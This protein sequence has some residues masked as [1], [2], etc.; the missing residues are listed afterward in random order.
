MINPK[1]RHIP[2]LKEKSKCPYCGKEVTIHGLKY[3]HKRY[4]KA[5]Q[6]EQQPAPMPKLERT[7]TLENV[8]P[9]AP[10]DEQI[11]AFIL[12]QR[13]MKANEKREK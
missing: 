6:S 1:T 2:E 7:A 4:C 13:K 11:A 8:A 9:V 3:T 5:N 12:N 10:T